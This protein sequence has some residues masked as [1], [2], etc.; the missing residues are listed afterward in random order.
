MPVCKHALDKYDMPLCQEDCRTCA[1][2]WYWL[3]DCI[4]WHLRV[5]AL[6]ELELAKIKKE[7]P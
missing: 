7:V 5:V 6:L 4:A 2:H 1:V 3:R